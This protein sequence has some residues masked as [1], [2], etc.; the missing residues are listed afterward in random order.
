MK[1]SLIALALVSSFAAVGVANAAGE[2]KS[3]FDVLINVKTSCEF[4]SAID[5]MD[6]GSKSATATDGTVVSAEANTEFA[7]QCTEGTVPDI[8]LASANNW[9]MKGETGAPNAGKEISY[10]LYADA[11]GKLPWDDQNKQTGKN[12]DGHAYTMPIYGK[13]LDVGRAAGNFSDVVTVTLQ[14]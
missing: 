14:F 11:D 4:A 9:K 1:R 8:F 6:F 10:K 3:T 5:K 2:A 7:I 12:T 13:V